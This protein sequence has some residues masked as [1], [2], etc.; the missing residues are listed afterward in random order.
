MKMGSIEAPGKN[1]ESEEH[2]RKK[3]RV[4][5]VASEG[6]ERRN[7][8]SA[9]RKKEGFSEDKAKERM[10][11]VRGGEPLTRVQKKR[12][13]MVRRRQKGRGETEAGRA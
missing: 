8:V 9:R 6:N 11:K 4:V 2:V 13:K 7:L 5:L 1:W 10:C 12:N 3:G